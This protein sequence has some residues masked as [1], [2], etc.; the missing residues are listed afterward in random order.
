MSGLGI[1]TRW[2]RYVVVEDARAANDAA[3]SKLRVQGW[4]N[5]VWA[6]GAGLLMPPMRLVMMDMHV[7]D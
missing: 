2:E 6:G 7:L 3:L 1:M 5:L 4:P